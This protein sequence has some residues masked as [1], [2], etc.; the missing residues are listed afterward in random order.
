MGRDVEFPVPGHVLDESVEL[1]HHLRN[2]RVGDFAPRGC[3][4]A[5]EDLSW[6]SSMAV[7]IDLAKLWAM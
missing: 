4:G 5:E 3:V 7:E 2:D 6:I 1:P